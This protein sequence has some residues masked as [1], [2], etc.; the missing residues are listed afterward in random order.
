MLLDLPD[1]K[2]STAK[3]VLKWA[4]GKRQLLP[5]LVARMPKQYNTFHEPFLGGGALYFHVQPERSVIA[6]ANPELINLYKVIANQLDPLIASLKKHKNESDYFY[7]LR[8]KNAEALSTVE[9]ASRT[10]YLNRTC[11]NGLYRVNK[12]G[13]FNV[14]FGKY[15][16]PNFCDEPTL[17]RAQQLLRRSTILCGDYKNVLQEHTQS[18][19]FVFLDPPYYPIS[20]S[21]DFKRYTKEQFR[22]Q[23]HID[24]AHEVAQLQDKGCS[25][26]L[27]NSNS[28]LVLD[29]YKDYKID[30]IDTKRNINSRAKLRTG[31]DV[32]VSVEPKRHFPGTKIKPGSDTLNSTNIENATV[33]LD[34]QIAKFPSTRFMGSKSKLLP[35]LRKVIE[36]QQCHTVLDLFAGS[37]VV[38][39]MLKAMGKEVHTNDYMAF[40]ALLSKALIENNHIRLSK[41]DATALLDEHVLAE[42]FVQEHFAGLYFSDSENRLI[43]TIRANIK[44]LDNP[45]QQAVATS[46]LVRACFKKRPRGIFTYVGQRYNDGRKDLKISLADHFLDAVD[47]IN[48]A[49]FD[50]GQQN[51]SSRDDALKQPD[52]KPDLVY[53]DPP[54]YSPHSD[55]EYVRR[56]H[57]VEGI[58][59]DWRD[60]E[61]QWHTKTKKFKSY[62]TPFSTKS[63]TRD[64]F[65]QLF[66]LYKD[67]TIVLSYSSNSEPTQE[68]LVAM[69]E[70]YKSN[71]EVVSVDHRYSFGNQRHKQADNNNKV[72]EYIFVAS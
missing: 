63:G 25:V 56:Y 1:N 51:N 50:N 34:E 13:Q 30:V 37:G 23:D 10:L 6:D 47:A 53:L 2:A 49:V 14:P 33:S 5:Q 61:M 21:S 22:E 68:E 20:D 36:A 66:S 15:A 42:P 40:S 19:D 69:L 72:S 71:V 27:T 11:F 24:L 64:A 57:F 4:G 48:N 70:K 54:Y 67:S 59:C 8:A 55:N 29:L 60:V 16:N 26:L 32:I 46:A 58:A 31:E 28:D 3:P 9:A 65:D 39:Y 35:H 52:F 12:K 41:Q 45:Y 38:S 44:L 62:P 17:R 43:D 18:G 7:A